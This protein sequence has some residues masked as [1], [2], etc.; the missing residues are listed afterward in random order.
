MKKYKFIHI[1]PIASEYNCQIVRMIN[2]N[3][4]VFNVKEHLFVIKDYRIYEKMK[5]YKN[6][7][8]EEDITHDYKKFIKYADSAEFIFLHENALMELSVLIRLRTRILRK[9][10]WVVW[11]HDLYP[12]QLA[13]SL[14]RKVSN[15][16]RKRISRRYYGVG[17][18]F[19]YDALKVREDYG[20]R[21]KILPLPYGYEALAPRVSATRS[22]SKD[23]FR[24]MVGH[25]AYEFLNHF[26]VLDRLSR[27]KNENI[28][29]CLVLAYGRENYADS[30]KKYAI[31]IFGKDKVEVVQEMMSREDY[32]G[33]LNSVDACI[34]DYKHQAALGNL[35]IL[36]RLGKK[37]FLRRDGVL[38]TAMDLENIE[39]Y[40][41]E[42]IDRMDFV[43]LSRDV[44]R[45]ENGKKFVD[46][47]YDNKNYIEMWSRSLKQLSC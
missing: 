34:L 23:E 33:Y 26:S 39:T 36:L 31:E 6:V 1:M 38:K 21:I 17:V 30:V 8:H 27:F 42:D 12:E 45:P 16:I 13:T 10:I 35:Y 15:A 32:I 29:V 28:K 5:A 7:V 40:N 41:V 2:D 44:S 43:E 14:K 25:S 37:V 4:S 18:G 22:S 19:K 46:F 47:Y 9:I 3:P 20:G 24:V 11:G